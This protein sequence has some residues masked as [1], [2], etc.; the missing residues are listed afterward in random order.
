LGV[1]LQIVAAGYYETDAMHFVKLITTDGFSSAFLY[2]K[3][4][5]LCLLLLLF[6]FVVL[7]MSSASS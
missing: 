4:L 3:Y 7:F 2:Q 1:L 6:S 5:H